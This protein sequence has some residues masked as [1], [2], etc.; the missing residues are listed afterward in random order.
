M[1][2]PQLQ[3]ANRGK[4]EQQI[5]W[6]EQFVGNDFKSQRFLGG[7]V[8]GRVYLFKYNG[9][10]QNNPFTKL[11]NLANGNIAIKVSNES[12]NEPDVGLKLLNFHLANKTD[13]LPGY[14]LM[15]PF[16]R[17]ENEPQVSLSQFVSFDLN[18]AS[19]ASADLKSLLLDL[20]NNVEQKPGIDK[21]AQTYSNDFD[22]ML[23]QFA[24]SAKNAQQAM[25]NA[26]FLHLDTAFRLQT[27]S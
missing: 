18:A 2:N 8:A 5:A 3:E 17:R 10:D 20:Y 25:H 15:L 4:N 22:I 11:S 12:D 9:T 27:Y 1:Q 16:Q 14:N 6:L 23:S 13:A 19:P 24:A 21:W 26:G 7:G